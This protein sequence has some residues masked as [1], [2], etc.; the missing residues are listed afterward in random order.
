M[1]QRDIYTALLLVHNIGLDIYEHG[2]ML[3][4]GDEWLVAGR[5]GLKLLKQD[6]LDKAK[7]EL[8]EYQIMAN[9]D[10]AALQERVNRL[11]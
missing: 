2:M 5:I 11:S 3:D 1:N 7:T 8:R 10:I 4:C 9:K 6:E